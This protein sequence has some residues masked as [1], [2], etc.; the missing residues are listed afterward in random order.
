M[1]ANTIY[2]M[3]CLDGLK[4]VES[5][6]IDMVMTSPPY[7]NLRDYNG[8]TFDFEN[9]AKELVRVL[10]KGGVIVWVVGDQVI[11]G[12]ESGTSF[13]QALYFKELG[14]NI[15]DTMIWEKETFTFPDNTRYRQIFE[16]M[17][18]F[19]KGKPKTFIPIKDKLNKYAGCVVSGTSR[20]IDGKT[21]RKSNEGNIIKTNGVRNNIWKLN[22]NKKNTIGHPATF[23]EELASDHINTWSNE[24]DLILDPFMGSGTTAK[25]C[26]E[27]GRYFIGFEISKEYCDMANKRIKHL[28]EQI[29]IF[30][31]GA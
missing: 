29:S 11:N 30:D 27:T 14:L 6:S 20:N 12:S 21:F 31:L 10:K 3:D 18:V 7:D 28:K 19:S 25:V 4:L 15:H 1:E 24:K 13:K 5:E 8:Y 2:N 16:F 22:T 17:F 26:L 9:I 23:P